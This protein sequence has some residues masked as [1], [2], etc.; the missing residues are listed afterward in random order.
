MAQQVGEGGENLSDTAKQIAQNVAQQ[1]EPKAAELNRTIEEQAH[2]ISQNAEP[3][4]RNVADTVQEGA[5]V[6]DRKTLNKCA[7]RRLPALRI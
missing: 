4:A 7:C 5:K 2:E 1:A 6:Y 3:W